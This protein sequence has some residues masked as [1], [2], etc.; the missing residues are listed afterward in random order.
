MKT[1]NKITL[2]GNLGKDPEIRK[3][4]G[5]VSVAKVTLATSESYKDD[6]RQT[7]THTEWHNIVLWR[8]LADLTEKYLKKGSTV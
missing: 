8:G 5:N 6:T 2:I 4:E 1:L 3:L 7:H